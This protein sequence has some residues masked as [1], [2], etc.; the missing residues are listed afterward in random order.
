MTMQPETVL[1]VGIIRII[2]ACFN[3]ENIA[4]IGQPIY[5]VKCADYHYCRCL[6]CLPEDVRLQVLAM[7]ASGK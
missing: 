2:G 3:C 7:M 6:K 5:D 1:E 4:S